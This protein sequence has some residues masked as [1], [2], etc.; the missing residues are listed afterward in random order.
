MMD[1]GKHVLS[2]KPIAVRF[3][4]LVSSDCAIHRDLVNRASP[5][6]C[7]AS[8]ANR[9]TRSVAHPLS[10]LI[11]KPWQLPT[12]LQASASPVIELSGGR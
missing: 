6:L 10:G 1:K 5:A 4:P 12:H 2:E 7:G 3:V 9:G 8:L 11:F